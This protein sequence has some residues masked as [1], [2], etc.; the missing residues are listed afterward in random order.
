MGR[1]G[2]QDDG[3]QARLRPTCAS[4]PVFLRYADAGTWAA[5]SSVGRAELWQLV[6]LATNLEPQFMPWRE[7]KG[8]ERSTAGLFSQRLEEAAGDLLAMSL[9]TA[10]GHLDMQQGRHQMSSLFLVHSPR[11]F[12]H[13]EKNGTA[14]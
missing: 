8:P 9:P 10:Q 4:S 1:P 2:V 12:V 13:A 5:W 14:T 6:A 3:A 11:M 7:I